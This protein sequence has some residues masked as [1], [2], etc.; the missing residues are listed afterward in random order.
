VCCSVLGVSSKLLGLQSKD[1]A[2]DGSLLC[3]H[4]I[5]DY[6]ELPNNKVSEPKDAVV[7]AVWRM[8]LC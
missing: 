8:G 4:S 5:G 2:T 1:A 3:T 7:Q 6:D